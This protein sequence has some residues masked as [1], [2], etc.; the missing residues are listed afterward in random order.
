MPPHRRPEPVTD[1]VRLL[2]VA[3][4]FPL[5]L[6]SYYASSSP[7]TRPI[8]AVMLPSQS[9]QDDET[10]GAGCSGRPC[11]RTRPRRLDASPLN[12]R[13]CE[14]SREPVDPR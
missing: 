1:V 5:R 8:A 6:A 7:P 2:A 12:A 3:A 9:R 13:L 4:L 11:R 14:R 10:T